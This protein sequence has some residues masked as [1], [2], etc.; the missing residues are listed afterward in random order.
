[1][2]NYKEQYYNKMS[3]NSRFI[4]LNKK[5]LFFICIKCICFIVY[6]ENV[7]FGNMH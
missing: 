6:L 3:S 7:F 4:F 1:M 2:N 5:K